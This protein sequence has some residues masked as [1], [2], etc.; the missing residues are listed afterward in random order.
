MALTPE[1]KVKRWLYGTREKP[2]VLFTYFP[3][4]YVYKPPGG[5]F[6]QAGAPDCFMLWQGVF[7]GLEVKSDDG[8]A[9]DLQ[10]KRLKQIIAQGGVGAVIKGKDIAKLQALKL[11]VEKKIQERGGK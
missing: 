7:V 3:G 10:I 4:A 8:E 2:G 1:G 5:M 6:G 9:T 11:A